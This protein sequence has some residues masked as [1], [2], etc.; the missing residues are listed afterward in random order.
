MHR[1]PELLSAVLRS[2]FKLALFAFLSVLVATIL[3][4]GLSAALLALLWSLLRGRKPA[5]LQTLMR[6]HQASRQF[7]GGNGSAAPARASHEADVVDVQAH[8]VHKALDQPR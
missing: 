6:F 5:G 7:R 8:E 2:L 1:I 4:I 3:L